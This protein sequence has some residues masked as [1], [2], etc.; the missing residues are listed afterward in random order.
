MPKPPERPSPS[1]TLSS[2][3]QTAKAIVLEHGGHV[4]TLIAEDDLQAIMIQIH[5][6]QPTHEARAA[7]FF[8]LGF[9]L[10][11]SGEVGVLQ[12]AFF[13]SEGWM[14]AAQLGK[15]PKVPPSQDPQRKEVLLVSQ[16]DVSTEKSELVVI[17]MIRDAAGQLVNLEDFQPSSEP[18]EH[19]I[20]VE[21]PLLLAFVNGF[22]QGRGDE[23]KL[24]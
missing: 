5:D 20:T 12:Q 14:S 13:I 15:A 9:T 3:V 8:I 24:Q 4:S 1:L 23:Q 17:E 16:L 22:L 21:N 2:I 7:Q 6:L 18:R 19:D 11:L 10:A